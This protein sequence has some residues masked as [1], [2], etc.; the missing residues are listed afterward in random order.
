MTGLYHNQC[1]LPSAMIGCKC[2]KS[3]TG[4]RILHQ[5]A[6]G[7]VSQSVYLLETV[8][9]ATVEEFTHFD[10]PTGQG[11]FTVTESL[12][13]F[14]RI[15]LILRQ[16]SRRNLNTLEEKSKVSFQKYVDKDNKGSASCD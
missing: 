8:Q 3:L 5:F 7:I 10:C 11:S 15:T 4:E 14:Y 6:H 1:P 13:G 9:D 2:T 16:C 12:R